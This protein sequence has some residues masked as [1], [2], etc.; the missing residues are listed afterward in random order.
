M[1]K[2]LETLVR[3]VTKL[4]CR[5]GKDDDIVVQLKAEL[6]ALQNRVAKIDPVLSRP[7]EH[8]YAFQTKAKQSFYRSI[9]TCKYHI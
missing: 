3:L 5:Y 8:R 7:S 9:N 4:E 1:Q 2:K 6:I